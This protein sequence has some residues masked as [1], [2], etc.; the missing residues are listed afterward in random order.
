M[1]DPRNGHLLAKIVQNHLQFGCFYSEAFWLFISE[2][3]WV[4][5]YWWRILLVTIWVYNELHLTQIKQ[6]G[7][8]LVTPGNQRSSQGMR[9]GINVG[10]SCVNFPLTIWGKHNKKPPSRK[11]SKRKFKT[12]IEIF[13]RK[14]KLGKGKL[15]DF[16][17][18][19][20]ISIRIS[21]R[22]TTLFWA[23]PKKL[24]AFRIPRL[25]SLCGCL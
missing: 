15:S 2:V 7:I 1:L 16:S 3:Q 5:G 10:C 23:L 25:T 6:I 13:E 8:S 17:S 24:Y 20:L 12:F 4:G 11:I 9:E 14:N 19:K 18:T 22:F 21:C